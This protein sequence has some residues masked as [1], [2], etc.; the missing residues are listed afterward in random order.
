MLFAKKN[1]FG[2]V[3]L[4]SSWRDMEGTIKSVDKY[5][6]API[7]RKFLSVGILIGDS[8][9]KLQERVGGFPK[10]LIFNQILYYF[11]DTS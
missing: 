4:P 1:H 2:Y 3:L 6:I 7:L 9:S 10:L 8:M 5:E 11:L